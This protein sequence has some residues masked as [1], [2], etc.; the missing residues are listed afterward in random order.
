M[1][2]NSKENVGLC[3]THTPETRPEGPS[4]SVV[5]IALHTRRRARAHCTSSTL[6]GGNQLR[7]FHPTLEGPTGYVNVIRWMYSLH[8]FLHGIEWIVFHW[9][10]GL[11]SKPHLLEVGQTQ[12]R[13]IMVLWMFIIVD[14][15][16]FI[17]CEDP[18]GLNFIEIAFG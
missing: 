5:T 1:G 13:E 4:R 11:F 10:F 7:C 8:G 18:H 12:N 6:I 9:S 16:Y 3:F 15:F 17:M 14:L 2:T